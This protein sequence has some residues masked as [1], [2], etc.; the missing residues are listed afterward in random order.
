MPRS[1][2]A[3]RAAGQR[4]ALISIPRFDLLPCRPEVSIVPDRVVLACS[5]DRFPNELKD[6]IADG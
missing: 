5:F 6:V 4:L 3:L 2:L 1:A